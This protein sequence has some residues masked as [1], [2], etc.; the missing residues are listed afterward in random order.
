MAVQ[1]LAPDLKFDRVFI[2]IYKVGNHLGPTHRPF[3]L[4]GEQ[5]QLVGF[6][7]EYLNPA[8]Q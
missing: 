3:V 2:E 7:F 1:K 8:G 4:D 6:T 5:W